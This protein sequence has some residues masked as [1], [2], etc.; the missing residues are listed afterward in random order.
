MGTT[1]ALALASIMLAYYELEFLKG[2]AAATPGMETLYQGCL[3]HLALR[4]SFR[5]SP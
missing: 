3:D 2:H 4:W 1:L 5:T